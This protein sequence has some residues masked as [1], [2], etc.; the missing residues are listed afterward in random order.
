[1]QFYLHYSAK[2][3]IIPISNSY[4]NSCTLH[5][6]WPAHWGKGPRNWYEF[7]SGKRPR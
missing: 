4:N 7:H 3:D 6:W 5:T 1:M 2:N